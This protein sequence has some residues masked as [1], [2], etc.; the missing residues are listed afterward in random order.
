MCGDMN[1]HL[2]EKIIEG[3]IKKPHGR[4]L[5]PEFLSEKEYILVNAT[6]LVIGGP[7]TRYVPSDANNEERRSCLDLVIISKELS[8]YVN[9]T[10]DL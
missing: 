4:K 2:G 6:D 9:F 5:S 10:V 3:N 7:F 8:N 1:K